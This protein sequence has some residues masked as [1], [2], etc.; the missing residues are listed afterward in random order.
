[1]KTERTET[2]AVE[3]SRRNDHSAGVPLA[4]TSLQVSPPVPIRMIGLGS[5]ARGVG[6]RRGVGGGGRQTRPP[7]QSRRGLRTGRRGSA[8]RGGS[9][10]QATGRR[11]R[12][13]GGVTTAPPADL[14]ASRQVGRCAVVHRP[15]R[16]G[17]PGAALPR[18]LAARPVAGRR[19][20]LS[21]GGG[22]DP[23]R[24][25]HLLG[26]DRGAAAAAVHLP[27]VRG[28]DRDSVGVAA[29]RRGRAG[30]GRSPRSRPPPRSSGMPGGGS[31]TAPA[32]GRRSPWPCSRCRCCGCTR[33]R[34]ASGSGR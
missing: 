22:V 29:L 12:Q 34:T 30:C 10:V 24:A 23:H 16:R 27:A 13:N 15:R 26:D 28:G 20:G 18:L 3:P 11:A 4:L 33:C 1:M 8:W 14:L 2:A 6:G 21:R 7:G 32:P 25:A 5:A 31:S 9:P 17:H 19:R